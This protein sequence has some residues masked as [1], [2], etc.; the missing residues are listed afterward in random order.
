MKVMKGRI[1][2][3]QNMINK[4]FDN[5]PQRSIYYFLAT[6][7]SFYPVETEKANEYEQKS[8]YE[9]I[10]GIYKNLYG[11]P[12]L[13]NIKPAPDDCLNDW[14]LQKEKAGLA[15]KI[16]GIIAKVDNFVKQLHQII[17]DG[18]P[19][20]EN[21]LILGA[22]NPAV[23]KQVIKQ[24]ENFGIRADKIEEKIIFIFPVPV[25]GLKLLAQI[26]SDIPL[27]PEKN[28]HL[29]FSRGVFD[30]T[31]PWTREI[32]SNMF[33]NTGPFEKLFDFLEINDYKRVDI[34]D[35]NHGIS[36]DYIKNYGPPDEPLKW[37]WAERTRGGIE[38]V[39]SEIRK[40]QP[41]ITMR[42][43][44]FTEVLKNADKMSGQVKNFVTSVSKK[45]DGCRYCVQT[46]KTGSRPF[47]YVD[48]DEYKICP[49]FCGFQYTW[50]TIDDELAGNIIAMLEFIDS[51]F[52]KK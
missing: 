51:I 25:R 29:Y 7:P 13:L 23:T 52:A 14:Q 44:Y 22:D 42:I 21:A 30:P 8:A 45:C 36:L 1:K 6:Y 31:A 19:S 5:L 46:D 10:L 4:D 15:P 47:I 20:D 35:Y 38:V 33:G 49:L 37:A 32:Y 40:N 3:M 50:K 11:N 17:T 43:P 28:V 18:I 2:I 48:V 24:I 39:Y 41:S 26:S 16:R 12:M 9:F 27:V 34:K